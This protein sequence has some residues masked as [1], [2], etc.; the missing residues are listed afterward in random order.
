M[1]KP[2]TALLP[3]RTPVGSEWIWRQPD[4]I[5]WD[6]AADTGSLKVRS[7]IGVQ[8]RSCRSRGIVT[9]TQMWIACVDGFFSTV[10]DKIEP[11]RMLIRAR[12]EKDI[13]N[14]Y[15]RY[16]DKCPS[17]R[18]PTSDD[19]R[20]YRYRLSVS[21]RDWVKLVAELASNVDYPNFKTAVHQLPDQENKNRPYLE[22]WS[23]MHDVQLDEERHN[24]KSK[25]PAKVKAE[26]V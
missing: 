4:K 3:R 23:I 14:L 24:R 11:G 17:M 19:S 8:W 18:E 20:D 21:K 25:R 6:R 26:S 16:R 9:V 22:I 7:R 13:K 15:D 5:S 1:F 2:Q 12:C 10:I